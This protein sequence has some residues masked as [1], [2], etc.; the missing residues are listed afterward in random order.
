MQNVKKLYVITVVGILPIIAGIISI[1]KGD[2]LFG[3]SL[4]IMG[5]SVPIALIYPSTKNKSKEKSILK[6]I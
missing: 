2:I 1:T 6:Q 4:L 3:L 5:V